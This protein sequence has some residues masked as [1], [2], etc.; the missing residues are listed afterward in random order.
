MCDHHKLSTRSFDE[1]DKDFYSFPTISVLRTDDLTI[2]YSQTYIIFGAGF[3][4]LTLGEP[5]LRPRLLVFTVKVLTSTLS[6]GIR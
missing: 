1:T 2:V 5:A 4:P 3:I 6:S